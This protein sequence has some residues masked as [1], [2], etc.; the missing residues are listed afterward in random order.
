MLNWARDGDVD[1]VNL[2]VIHIPEFAEAGLLEPI[3]LD[4]HN[5]FLDPLLP[6]LR[7]D[8]VDRYWAAP[9]NTD[10]GMMFQRFS[11]QPGRSELLPLSAALRSRAPDGS[12]LFAGQLRPKTL[13]SR[14][15]F[16]INVLEHALAQDPEIIEPDGTVSYEVTRWQRALSPLR[17][18]VRSPGAP[19]ADDE[20]DTA[21]IFEREQLGFMRN[22]PVRYRPFQDARRAQAGQAGNT[23]IGLGALPIGILGGQSLAVVAKSPHVAEAVE[24]VRFLT[25]TPAQRA[26]A[27]FGFAPTRM[28]AYDDRNLKT[29]LPHLSAIRGAVENSRPRP[30]HRN[31]GAF[32]EAVHTHVYRW[33]YDGQQAL[34]TDLIRDMKLALA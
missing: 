31:Y 27:M 26:L 23:G 28:G 11:D 18:Y 20:D 16:V 19:L 34:T 12:G 15:A 24:A 5:E 21:A 30:V 33:L 13:A 22:W 3:E 7:A 6:P 8:D 32:S 10:V 29:F 25:D 17:E 4:G 14:E 9:F 2:D 1:I